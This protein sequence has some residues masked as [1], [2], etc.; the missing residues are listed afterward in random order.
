MNHKKN[1]KL[2][3]DYISRLDSPGWDNAIAGRVAGVRTQR[4]RRATFFVSLFF[5]AASAGTFM[6]SLWQEDN[7]QTQIVAAIEQ[8]ADG[9]IASQFL[10]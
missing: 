9:L 5:F 2:N 7:S 3:T 1:K 6:F 10:E 8:E 4:R